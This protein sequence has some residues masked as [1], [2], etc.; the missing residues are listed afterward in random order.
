MFRELQQIQREEKLGSIL[1]VQVGRKRRM[2]KK[3]RKRR[4]KEKRKGE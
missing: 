4:K 1:Y 2:K 3:K